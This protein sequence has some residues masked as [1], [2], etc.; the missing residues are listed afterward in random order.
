MVKAITASILILLS[1]VAYAQLNVRTYVPPRAHTVIPF[2]NTELDARWPTIP[3][4]SFVPA[5]IE[6][7]SCISLSHS[8]CF[9]NAELKTYREYGFGLG[10]FTIAYRAD[11]TER[12]NAWAELRARHPELAEWTWEQ[13]MRPDLQV[14]AIVL[15]L[16]TSYATLP[17]PSTV[18]PVERM[19]FLAATYNSGSTVKD[20]A[21]C[22]TQPGCDPNK[23]WGNVELY[24]V[25]SKK[26]QPGYGRSFYQISRE[27]VQ[28]TINIRRPKYIPYVGE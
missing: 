21:F 7:E 6:T 12:F 28:S 15:K 13:R 26:V 4:R 19:P 2:I 22:R 10:Q 17:L 20:R 8:R 16:R 14:R 9:G 1:S 25:K 24:S 11:G 5:L 18:P 23:W 27:Y 3:L